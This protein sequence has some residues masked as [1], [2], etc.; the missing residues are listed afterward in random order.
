MGRDKRPLSVVFEPSGFIG[1]MIETASHSSKRMRL[2]RS[3]NKSTHL[4]KV[5]IGR[6]IEFIEGGSWI[7][8]LLL[9]NK[10]LSGD[11]N[12]GPQLSPFQNGTGIQRQ[13]GDE[14][15]GYLTWLYD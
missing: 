2:H 12:P 15:L 10:C 8:G 6:D 9:E 14:R 3:P 13:L 1:G 4:L 11:L 7:I 5:T